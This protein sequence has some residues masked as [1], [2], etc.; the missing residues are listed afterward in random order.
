VI[1]PSSDCNGVNDDPAPGAI[2]PKGWAMA[3]FVASS[4]RDG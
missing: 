3:R 4:N 1:I 2:A